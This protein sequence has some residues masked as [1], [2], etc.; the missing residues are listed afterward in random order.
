MSEPVVADDFALG[1]TVEF[2]RHLWRLNHA[3]E[4]LSRR[5]EVSWGV[6]AQ[7]RMIV[8]CVGRYPGITANQLAGYLH[9][10][11]G[12]VS[13]AVGRLERKGLLE[14]RRADRDRRRLTLGLT[15]AGRGIDQA[16]ASLERAV[17][18]LLET[19]SAEELSSTRRV[20]ASLTALLEGEGRTCPEPRGAPGDAATSHARP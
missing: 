11:A 7:Q 14:R 4:R 18:R 19:S 15:A 10:D 13:A 12:T 16:A 6:T 17:E 3:L 5:M 20:L 1:P 2:L 8:R 9:V